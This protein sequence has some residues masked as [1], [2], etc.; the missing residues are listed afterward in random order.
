MSDRPCTCPGVRIHKISIFAY[1]EFTSLAMNSLAE[2]VCT[3]LVYIYMSSLFC[4]Y[5]WLDLCRGVTRGSI[6]LALT[7]YSINIASVWSSSL[8]ITGLTWNHSMIM[9]T[10][11]YIQYHSA[12]N[13]NMYFVMWSVNLGEHRYLFLLPFD[14]KNAILCSM[15]ITFLVLLIILESHQMSIGFLAWGNQ[16]W[17]LYFAILIQTVI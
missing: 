14:F 1:Y 13:R 12:A 2:D 3:L 11:Y 6:F 17:H 7:G 10:L 8:V 9:H 16:T 5:T 15:E 4:W